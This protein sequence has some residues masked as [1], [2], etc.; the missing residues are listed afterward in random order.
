M[1]TRSSTH[2]YEPRHPDRRA[3]RRGRRPCPVTAGALLLLAAALVPAAAWAQA[4]DFTVVA[5]GGTTQEVRR[6]H[7]FKPFAE[8]RKIRVLEDVYLGGW[9]VFQAMKETG[10]VPW[11][12]VQVESAELMRGC[13]EGVFLPIDW[14]RV[15]DRAQ[16][17]PEAV[18]ECGVGLSIWASGVAFSPEKVGKVP[19]RLEDFW[20]LKTWPGKRGLR[21]GP[22]INLEMALMA[23]GVPR[24]Q[25]YEVLAT[26]EGVDRA[27]RKLDRIKPHLMLWEAGAQST[28][29]LLS[30]DVMLS[31]SYS[32]R[33]FRGRNEGLSL[34]LI[35][36]RAVYAVDS[37]AVLAASPHIDLAYGFLGFFVSSDRHLEVATL[38]NS[39]LP[40]IRVIDRMDAEAVKGRPLKDNLKSALFMG[41]EESIG[42][43]LDN[44]DALTQRW[45]AWLGKK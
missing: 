9:G 23:D 37:W 25:V 14:A 2:G 13:E 18:S 35:W 16:F 10:Q 7:Y 33:V 38:T 27:F 41:T 12:V 30:G 6:E 5:W 40:L 15:A 45:N 29:R 28:D 11:D 26:P 39:T 1:K 32:T 42:F 24:E 22:K 3:G 19:T 31:T 44:Q 17:M 34:D 36:D 21:E 20:D 8:A 4:R 43:W